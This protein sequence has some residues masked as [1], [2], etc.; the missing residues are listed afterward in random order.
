MSSTQLELPFSEWQREPWGGKAPRSL[1]RGSKALFLRREPQKDDRFFVD[2]NQVDMWLPAKKAPWR[3]RGAPL[4]KEVPDVHSE[5]QRC[6]A[7]R[8]REKEY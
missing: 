7:D 8:S 5:T 1:T 6:G 3:Y 2:P 4:L